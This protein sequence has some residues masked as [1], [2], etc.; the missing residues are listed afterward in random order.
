MEHYV[1]IM[2][3]PSYHMIYIGMTS[4]LAQRIQSHKDK[5]VEGFT[6]KF[7]C[8]VCVYFEQTPDRESALFR[9]KQ[10]KK[11]SRIKKVA[12]IRSLNPDWDELFDRIVEMS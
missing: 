10:I 8:T 5:L 3:S 7:N 11:Y 1:Y 6:R 12:L 9:E 2:A 4:N